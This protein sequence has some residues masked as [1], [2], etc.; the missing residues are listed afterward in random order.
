[1][2][3]DHITNS[4]PK[5]TPGSK[6]LS[7]PW[8]RIPQEL[9]DLAQWVV[10]RYEKR[11]DKQTK[12]PY[13]PSGKHAKSSDPATWATFDQVIAVAE[14]FDGIGYVFSADDP[15]TG[16]DF[17]APLDAGK[18]ATVKTLGSY[19]ERSPSGNGLHVIVRAKLRGPG[20]NDQ[21][22]GREIYDRGRYFT[23]TGAHVEGT[24]TSIEARQIE[25]DAY[26]T[27][28]EDNALLKRMFA[29]KGGAAIK[30]LWN[31][32]LSAHG[33]DASAADLALCNHLA[34]WANKDAQRI[35]RLFRQS[36][37]YREKWDRNAR[38]GET[39]GQG[40]IK[41][42]IDATD[43]PIFHTNGNAPA[44]APAPPQDAE[45][46]SGRIE[47]DLAA[48]GYT[49]ATNDL[50]D[51]IWCNGEP[52]N[53][54]LAAQIRTTARNHGYGA[55][56]ARGAPPPP[57][58]VAMEDAYTAMAH[59]N[60]FH[61]I[62]DYLNGLTWDGKD[63]FGQLVL[64]LQSPQENITYPD[65][66]QKLWAS[67]ALYRWL[68]A[69]IAKVMTAG[70]VQ[71][72]MLVLSGPQGC[73]KS[74]LA[75]W[76]CPLPQY[77]IEAPIDPDSK[78]DLFVLTR[79]FIWEVSELGATTR[80]RDREALKAF[81]TRQEVTARKPYGRYEITK[82]AICAFV[83]TV[84]SAGGFLSDPTGARRFVVLEISAINLAYQT[85]DRDQLWAQMMAAYRQHPEHWRMHPA[86]IEAQR[87]AAEAAA[88]DYPYQHV[89]TALY[90]F[91]A[92]QDGADWFLP[93]GEIITALQAAD[94][95]W[96]ESQH[97]ALAGTLTALGAKKIERRIDKVKSRGWQGLKRRTSVAAVAA[98]VAGG[99]TGN[100]EI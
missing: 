38:T 51:A 10:W 23:M 74:T 40:T 60:R 83:G 33:G 30:A 24:P 81:L 13:N 44:V 79:R 42:A 35:D 25:I 67:V 90:E 73:G 86:E 46:L 5:A 22:A 43:A 91:D 45:T 48:W 78:D 2:Q 7:A 19:T 6:E 26:Y 65:G 9:R 47:T 88:V 53:D 18:L 92:K 62:R 98:T 29:S 80:R 28:F 49:F 61:P 34:F 71:A 15:Y 56:G 55:P 84:N 57:S 1:M 64:C 66:K 50:D 100:L 69:A 52:M 17:D 3:S 41:R 72:P 37:L 85:L 20:H 32:D 87:N 94:V 96:N 77:F 76:L 89:L 8:Q 54:A 82:P 95:S 14:R 59:R 97:G 21:E 27:Q 16:C 4:D 75:R 36:R 70:Q 99:A 58:I 39:Y 63:R 31:G 93:T 11:G 68:Q 12:V